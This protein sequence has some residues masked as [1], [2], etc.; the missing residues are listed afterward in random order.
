MSQI[1]S[2]DEVDA[3][4]KGISD[5]DVE[6][7]LEVAADTDE[8]LAYDF[9]TPRRIIR[10]RMPTLDITNE[11]FTRLFRKTLSAMMR[12]VIGINTLSVA[13]S[14]YEDFLRTLPLPSSLHIF[15]MEPLKGDML[16]IVE[17]KFI[18][19]L[20]DFLF[21]GSGREEYKVE[22]RD[23]TPI[24]NNLIKKVVLSALSDLE[25][26]WKGLLKVNITYKRSEM[27]PQF[28]QI[29]APSDVV[30]IINFEI[31]LDYTSG[32]ITVCIPYSSL[33][34][35]RDKLQGGYQTDKLESDQ[36]WLVRFKEE[37]KSS[38][39]NLSVELG[40]TEL[41]GR[42]ILTLKKGDVIL[43]DQH[44]S[45][46]MNVFLEQSLK[47]KGRPAVYRGNQAITVSQII[48]DEEV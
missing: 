14:K 5:G 41:T 46:D 20:V 9:A 28:A 40:K 39:I 31:E 22:G 6:T 16:F 35:L 2:Q 37:L 42:D 1:L 7:E 33:E 17:S 26:A 43:L 36:D 8:V 21:G 10:G 44:L 19:T 18:F 48:M 30:V 47:L 23:F 27:N 24:E 29:V 38:Y 13:F 4:L 12:R 3:L 15:K 45:D 34:P 32:T 25:K 11:N